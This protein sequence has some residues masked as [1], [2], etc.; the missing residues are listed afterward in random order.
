MATLAV[1]LVLGGTATAAAKRTVYTSATVKNNSITGADVK[2]GTLAWADLSAATRRALVGPDGGKG[3]TGSKGATGI[4]GVRGENGPR[5]SAALMTSAYAFR[6]TG[7]VTW[8]SNTTTPN[9]GPGNTGYD[10]DDPAYASDSGGGPYPNIR[11]AGAYESVSLTGAWTPVL[12]LTG[13][14]G[15]DVG[16]RSADTTV[17]VTFTDAV[18]NATGTLTF[19]H[20]NDDE[21]LDSSSGGTLRHGRVQCA[22]FTGTS[23]DPAALATQLGVDAWASSGYDGL[24][25]E[26]VQLSLNGSA[27]G[28]ASGASYNA[29][30]KCR[31]ADYTGS[32]QWQLA[33]G[34]LTALASR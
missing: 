3:A 24:R 11:A 10:W 7:L 9:N 31:D 28:I 26:L 16:T 1:L 6:D 25:H 33:S 27:G 22:L 29:T 19:L 12:S 8:R 30:V 21:D 14:S 5:G 2:N 20:R 34:N 18:L 4:A 17:G 13:M 23:S 15:S 32:V